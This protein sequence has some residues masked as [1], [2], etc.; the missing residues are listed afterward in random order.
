MREKQANHMYFKELLGAF[1][2]TLSLYFSVISLPI[3]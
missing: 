2:F 1:L 3:R